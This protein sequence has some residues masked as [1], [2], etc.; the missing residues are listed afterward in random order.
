MP[1][2]TPYLNS[3]K[4]AVNIFL[5]YRTQ[6]LNSVDHVGQIHIRIQEALDSIKLLVFAT[7]SG[8]CVNYRNVIGLSFQ[9]EWGIFIRY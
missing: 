5:E 8:R 2:L 7:R 6:S 9:R 4:L 1:I 3:R